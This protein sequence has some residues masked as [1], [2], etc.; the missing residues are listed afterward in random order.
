MSPASAKHIAFVQSAPL[1]NVDCVVSF[2]LV[3]P[4]SMTGA[5]ASTILISNAQ[6][7]CD[8]DCYVFHS[9]RECTAQASFLLRL[10]SSFTVVDALQLLC[11]KDG[12]S[13]R[14][15]WQVLGSQ[16]STAVLAHN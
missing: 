3:A 1:G 14:K 7:C 4:R 6:A 11:G 8:V 10:V 2:Q 12:K 13:P 15:L 9:I 16:I 5:I